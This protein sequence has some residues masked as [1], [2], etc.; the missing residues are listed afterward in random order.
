MREM[1]E[2]A[3]ETQ[4][5]KCH[6]KI[7]AQ[8]LAARL[9][10]L[11]KCSVCYWKTVCYA[12]WVIFC[13]RGRGYRECEA[14]STITWHTDGKWNDHWNVQVCKIQIDNDRTGPF[15]VLSGWHFS[16]MEYCFSFLLPLVPLFRPL[17]SVAHFI[18][19]VP[20]ARSRH[21]SAPAHAS[22]AFRSLVNRTLYLWLSNYTLKSRFVDFSRS[23]HR[24]LWCVC[25][26]FQRLEY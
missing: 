2:I 14:I 23:I 25:T 1:C 11:A 26:R 17:H 5:F 21:H 19:S 12:F 22:N 24:M 16:S 8:F 18:V 7:L 6:G 15:V 20:L 3:R 10:Q 4:P 9:V 13:C